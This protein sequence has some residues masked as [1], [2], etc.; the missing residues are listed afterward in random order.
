MR[1]CTVT[2]VRRI[3]GGA[4]RFGLA[5]SMSAALLAGCSAAGGEEPTGLATATSTPTSTPTP[6][7]TSSA[8]G[9]VD[10]SNAELGIAFTSLPSTP[11]DTPEAADL[12]A[13]IDTYTGFEQEFWR[14]LKEG[15]M[16][17]P[18]P[19]L[20]SDAVVA[21]VQTQL[22]TSGGAL[23]S[24]A[25]AHSATLVTSDPST[26]VLDTCRDFTGVSAVGGDGRATALGPD[27]RFRTT[28]TLGRDARGE[29]IVTG[30]QRAG[31]C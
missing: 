18:I 26:V 10:R 30:Y 21:F 19:G 25:V 1:S 4:S 3:P 9:P 23:A 12:R 24:G 22:D 13:A 31:S 14:T 5:L 20:A 27:A 17:L 15:K 2:G 28:V 7:P 29:W 6:S 11:E 16:A 8:L